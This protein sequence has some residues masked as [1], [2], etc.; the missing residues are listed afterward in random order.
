MGKRGELL[1]IHHGTDYAAALRCRKRTPGGICDDCRPVWNLY[2]RER[3]RND[4]EVRENQRAY[5]RARTRAWAA[6]AKRYPTEYW[7]LLD[8]EL[9]A[10][11]R[12]DEAA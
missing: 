2:H 6:L 7:A 5:N 10:A 3:R 11:K 9:K 8:Q 4:A 12:L 1:P